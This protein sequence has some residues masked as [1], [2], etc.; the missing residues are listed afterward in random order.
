MHGTKLK[1]CSY[2]TFREEECALNM[3]EM[4][5]DA[6]LVDQQHSSKTH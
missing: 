6:A 3:E 1:R 2:N 4:S 5:N